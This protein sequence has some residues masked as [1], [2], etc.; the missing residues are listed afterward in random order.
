MPF[1]SSRPATRGLFPRRSIWVVGGVVIVLGPDTL[2]AGKSRRPRQIPD[3]GTVFVQRVL[4]GCIERGGGLIGFG[5]QMVD[6]IVARASGV[7]SW[8][9]LVWWTTL[10]GRARGGIVAR[11]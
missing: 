9:R 7:Q 11:P 1:H 6:A 2:A 10:G 3:Q 5:G 4:W 8:V